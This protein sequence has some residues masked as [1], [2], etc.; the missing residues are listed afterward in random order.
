MSH[1]APPITFETVVD[2][3]AQVTEIA[4]M[5]GAT[6]TFKEAFTYI[7]FLYAEATNG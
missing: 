5:T 3:L 4:T 2:R 1:T 7:E 6:N